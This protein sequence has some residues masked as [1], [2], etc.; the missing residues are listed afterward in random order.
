[1][2]PT[3][4]NRF[5]EMMSA[6]FGASRHTLSAYRND[7]ARAQEE[8]GELGSAWLVLPAELLHGL[9]FA[10]MWA[11]SVLF[12]SRYPSAIA[13]ATRTTTSSSATRVTKPPGRALTGSSSG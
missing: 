3:A 4:A 12:A 1:M 6:E 8:I 9:T 10:A 11:A 5:L 7:L 13:S 2:V